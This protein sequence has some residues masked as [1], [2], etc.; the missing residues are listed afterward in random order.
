M[1]LGTPAIFLILTLLPFKLLADEPG[2]SSI[3]VT[4]LSSTTVTSSGEPIELPHRDVELTAS[5]YEIPVGAKL[6]EHMHPFARYGY[7]LAGTLRI[8][9]VESGK[10]NVFK[11]GDF[12]VETIGHWHRAENIGDEPVRLL[13]IDQT[14]K[15]KENTILRK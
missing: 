11:A 15:G 6:P 3:K 13:V 4:T 7:V 8:T 5:I 1:K 2:Q 12:I 14:E 10:S 9:N